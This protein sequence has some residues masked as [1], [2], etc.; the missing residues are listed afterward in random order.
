MNKNS[1]L[2]SEP[3]SSRPKMNGK[4]VI[5]VDARTVINFASGFSHKLLCDGITFSTGSAC[6]YTCEYC[7]VPDMMRRNPHKLD[8]GLDHASIVVRRRNPIEIL[9]R[10]LT[11]K[12]GSSRFDDPNDQRVIFASPLVDV[13]ANMVLVRETIEACLLILRTTNWHIRLL[14]KSNL[15]PKVAEALADH[16]SRVIY[17]VS[18][19]TLSDGLARAFE[20]DAPL[21]SQRIKSLHRLQDDGFRT[22]G[23]ICPSL[24]QPD[25]EAYVEFAQKCAEAIC[26]ERCE[27]VWAEVMNVRGDSLLNTTK[28]L[29]NA[30]YG[31]EA[32]RLNQVSQDGPEWEEYARSTFAA[33][34]AVYAD[35]PG[36]LRFMQ[37]VK[38]GTRPYWESRKTAGAI[39]L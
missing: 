38:K 21:V 27:H 12:D 24:P 36:K 15:L 25:F 19:G 8:E 11:Y 26:A 33:H 37:Y 10:Q 32:T 20:P 23:M 31:A 9:E 3:L 29:R 30:G 17:G 6:S 34:A 4:P 35:Q 14:S 2:T 7:Y 5:E 13:A 28:A 39:L 18:T 22:F 16:K 1:E